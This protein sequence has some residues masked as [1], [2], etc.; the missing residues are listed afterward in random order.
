MLVQ[1]EVRRA[2]IYGD[3]QL[4]VQ[5]VNGDSQCL[6]GTLNSN[7]EKCLEIMDDMD[8]V[9]IQHVSLQDNARANFLAQQASR[10]DIWRGKFEVKR[11]PASGDVLAIYE[12]DRELV[13]EDVA[14]R[15]GDW[16]QVLS[17]CISEPNCI[18]DRKV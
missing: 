16:R 12:N 17:E 7:R 2:W 3:S 10:Y 1:L 8:K 5:R 18:R 9:V 13:A 15:V 6:D 4:V 11:R 14:P